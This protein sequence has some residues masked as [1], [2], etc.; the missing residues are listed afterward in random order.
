MA[1]RAFSFSACIITFRHLLHLTLIR[2]FLNRK[3]YYHSLNNRRKWVL[4]FIL[5]SGLVME[6]D[7]E[8]FVWR[9]A[10]ERGIWLPMMVADIAFT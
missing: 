4:F 5:G 2:V 9:H 7:K 3:M 6:T 10:A 8:E 1:V